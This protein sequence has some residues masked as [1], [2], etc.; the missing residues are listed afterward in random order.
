MYA[1]A[2]FHYYASFNIT[3]VT[4]FPLRFLDKFVFNERVHFFLPV[5]YIFCR[6]CKLSNGS[7]VCVFCLENHVLVTVN[8]NT[9]NYIIN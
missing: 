6:V 3:A 8:F 2:S 1:P 4:F 7:C 5:I 9:N